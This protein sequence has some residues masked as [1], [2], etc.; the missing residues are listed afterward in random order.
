MNNYNMK[1]LNLIND[2]LYVYI[3]K[4]T[5]ENV[6][7]YDFEDI[8]LSSGHEEDT[9]LIYVGD[10]GN[11]WRRRCRG[12]NKP[13]MKLYMFPEPNIEDYR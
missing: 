5:L 13:N 10:I 12:I 11:N 3:G 2:Q 1:P 8:A 4:I 7:Q 6:K 9:D